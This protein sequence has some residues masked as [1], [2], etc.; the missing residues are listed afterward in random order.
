[1]DGLC[2]S[3]TFVHWRIRVY[4]THC[5]SEVR[6]LPRTMGSLDRKTWSNSLC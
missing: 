2:T 1:M 4:L 3:E 5:R 6:Q